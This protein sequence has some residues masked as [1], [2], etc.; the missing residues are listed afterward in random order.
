MK[1]L[2]K[3]GVYCGLIAVAALTSLPV[4]SA[5]TNGG[6]NA[7]VTKADPEGDKAW[8]EVE[9]ALKPPVPPAEWNDK[10]PS[11]EEIAAFNEKQKVALGQ[12]IDKAHE[13]YTKFPQ[14]PKAEDARR[15]EYQLL[16]Y[17]AQAGIQSRAK[18]LEARKEERIKNGTAAE[19]ER[20]E[21]KFNDVQKEAMKKKSEGQAAVMAELEKGV[22]QLQK[23]FPKRNELYEMLLMIASSSDDT[24]KTREIA[25]EISE[26]SASDELKTGAADLIKKLDRVGKPLA[27]SFKSVDGREVD[28]TKMTN[29]V[30]LIDF[31]ATWCGPCVQEI[32]NV[33]AAYD[34]LHSK[35]FEIIGLSFD[36]DKSKLEKF[37][38]EKKMGWPQYFD[39]KGWQN[40]Y[41]QEFGISSIPT[42]WLLD[43]KGIL[44]DVNAREDLTA[45]V[46]KFLAE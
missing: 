31:W 15:T 22:R 24:K 12:A 8:V 6:T 27:I 29:K 36:Q 28:T 32:P 9:K 45:K 19:D 46:E 33:K 7:V 35:G 5:A 14:H 26:S 44:R 1:T 42:M 17:A 40:K 41:G 43:K 11:K 25:K 38:A 20:F 34:K 2:A 18:D 10:Q 4:Q 13:F 3:V 23:E 30:I 21:K 39:G 37:V 16:Q